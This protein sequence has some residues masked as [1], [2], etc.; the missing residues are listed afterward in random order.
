LFRDVLLT[1]ELIPCPFNHDDD[2]DTYFTALAVDSPGEPEITA[3]SSRAPPADL[4]EVI[5]GCDVI[6]LH[7]SHLEVFHVAV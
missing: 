1:G 6:S 7:C 5:A 3:N 4:T 2:C